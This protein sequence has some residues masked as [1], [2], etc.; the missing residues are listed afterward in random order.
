M[1]SD[2]GNAVA[3][4]YGLAYGVGVEVANTLRSVGIDLAAYN[5]TTADELPL[6][7]TFLIGTDGVIAWAQVEA[8]FERPA[9][10]SGLPLAA[11][12]QLPAATLGLSR[13]RQLFQF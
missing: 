1:L 3:R 5:G 6:T 7:A 8:N 2:A 11:L 9:R 12:A 13:S 10:P 4:R